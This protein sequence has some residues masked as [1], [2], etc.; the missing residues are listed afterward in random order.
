MFAEEDELAAPAHLGSGQRLRPMEA[1]SEPSG[2]GRTAAGDGRHAVP[3]GVESGGERGS[4][5]SGAD[6]ADG[7]GTFSRTRAQRVT[8]PP[9]DAVALAPFTRVR[10]PLSPSPPH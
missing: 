2:G 3:G 7:G 6:E 10:M 4:E 9:P 8:S 5:A 1:G